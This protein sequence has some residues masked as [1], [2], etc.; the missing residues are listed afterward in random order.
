MVFI[1][2]Y[3][4]VI[5]KEAAQVVSVT[6]LSAP[7]HFVL[8]MKSAHL[9]ANSRP[10]H[11]IAVA[12]DTGS[13]ILRKPFSVYTVDKDAGE[14]SI[15]FSVYGPTTTAMSRMLPGD[16]IDVLGPLG[17]RIFNPEPINGIHHILVGGGYGVPPLNYLAKSIRAAAPDANV[18]VIIG[19]RTK[20][21]LVGDEGL[22]DA[23]VSVIYCTDDGSAGVH[24]RVTDALL[25]LLQQN[26]RVY[27]CGPTPMMKA[28]GELSEA[29]GVDCQVSLETF[30]PCGVG[31]CVGCVVKKRDG[32]YSRTCT[33]GPVYPGCEVAW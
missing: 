22:L 31:I 32:V 2:I 19:A 12:A 26:T 5:K 21:L 29:H 1:R 15:L 3:F 9:A 4:D 33:D 28:V 27:T 25:P 14:I 24:G 6:P 11:F 10:G 8:T 30:M 13:A 7:R 16:S 20:N 17:G 18:T 23:G